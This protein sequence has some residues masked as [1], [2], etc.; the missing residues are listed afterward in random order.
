MIITI[1]IMDQSGWSNGRRS[2]QEA[3]AITQILIEGIAIIHLN[4][5][6]SPHTDILRHK[7]TDFLLLD[8]VSHPLNMPILLKLIDL[9]VISK[10]NKLI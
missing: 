3:I 1:A 8:M 5:V 2:R 10:S 4:T 9:M 7:P 6:V